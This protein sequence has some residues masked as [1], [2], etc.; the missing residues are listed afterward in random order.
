MGKVEIT[1]D[2]CPVF[3]KRVKLTN[4]VVELAASLEF[5]P[6]VLSFSLCGKENMLYNDKDKKTLGD[7]FDIYGGDQIRLCGGHRIWIS[8]EVMP[9]CYHPDNKPVECVEIEDGLELRGAVEEKNN[10]QKIMVV[11]MDENSPRVS[12]RHIIRNTGLWD[13]EFAPWCITMMAPGGKT[14]IPMSTEKT[15]ALPNRYLTLW[16]YSDMSDPRVN[17]GK[18]FIT[19]KQDESMAN[20]F[21]VGLSNDKGWAAY[22]NRGQV[23]LK[24]F[25][26]DS[27]L[28]NYPDNGCTYESYT[29]DFMLEMETLGEIMLVSP[30]EEA[31]ITEEWE[32]YEAPEAPSDDG[33]AIKAALKNKIDFNQT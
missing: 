24:F 26:P 22:F 15:G 8:P 6:R 3:G 16:D 25:E 2:V 27:V 11:K 31:E 5:G 19:I 13:V 9:R 21:K 20:P 14:V 29:N 33:E 12:L 18:E 4:G 7:K 32:I 1:R 30:D 10:I 23:F 17:W 28:G